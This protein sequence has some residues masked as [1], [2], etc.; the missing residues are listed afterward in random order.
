MVPLEMSHLID[1]GYGILPRIILKKKK[2]KDR[3]KGV[4]VAEWS[5]ALDVRLSE[6]Y[7]NI[8]IYYKNI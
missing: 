4:D 6:W 7:C 8:Y 5:R 3:Y 1:G 2:Q